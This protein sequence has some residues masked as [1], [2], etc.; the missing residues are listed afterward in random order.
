M[1][2]VGVVEEN[3]PI[4]IA[5][6]HTHCELSH[7]RGEPIPLL[8]Q[9]AVCHL[10]L[11]LHL[12]VQRLMNCCQQVK[13]FGENAHVASALCRYAMAG[14]GRKQHCVFGQAGDGRHIGLKQRSEAKGQRE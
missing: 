4:D 9:R 14:V 10:N 13:L 12:V 11:F 5:D 3:T 2:G 8:R 7:E 6:Q 1:P